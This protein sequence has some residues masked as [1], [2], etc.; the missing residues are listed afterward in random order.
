V[1]EKPGRK[2]AN[3]GAPQAID[4]GAMI[5]TAGIKSL[6]GRHV[7]ERPDLQYVKWHLC[8]ATEYLPLWRSDPMVPFT[9]SRG[10]YSN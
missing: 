6:L 3:C 1:T 5:H 2:G 4:I 8:H 10:L 9:S 7:I